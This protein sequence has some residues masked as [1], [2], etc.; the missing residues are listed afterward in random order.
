[1]RVAHFSD[2]HLGRRQ[3]YRATKSGINQR[4]AD[5]ALAFRAAVDDIVA[6]GPDLI[7][8]A[9]DVFHSVLPSNLARMEAARQFKRLAEAAPTL[10]IAGNHSTPKT[11][12][13]GSPVQLLADIPNVIVAAQEQRTWCSADKRVGVSMMPHAAVLSGQIPL[14]SGG[15]L[16]ILLIH[17]ATPGL[18]R[19]ADLD[20]VGAPFDPSVAGAW[21]YVALGDYHVCRQ[22]APNAWYAGSLEFVSSNP[23]GEIKERGEKGWLLVTLDSGKS[24]VVAFRPV[25]TRSH[26]DFPVIDGEGRSSAEVAA[27]IPEIPFGAVVRQ[28]V[29][30]MSRLERRAL[31]MHPV[32]R[33]GRLA[34]LHFNLD[35]RIQLRTSQDINAP[36][37]LE[38][39]E[40]W[41]EEQDREA[42]YLEPHEYPETG[43]F[44]SPVEFNATTDP[45]LLST[46]QP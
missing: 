29:T 27:L 2:L 3:F 28:V 13:Q 44:P 26:L 37:I 20:G 39:R 31:Q 38:P 46:R 14:R 19:P 21:A 33:S 34:A 30:G 12:E 15:D 10:I 25:A 35:A 7:L 16:E 5:A 24:P 40:A 11:I 9:G 6:A 42:H 4:E 36:L 17:G 8:C 1:M 32:V 22:V 23:W 43:P 41:E 18:H 45:Y